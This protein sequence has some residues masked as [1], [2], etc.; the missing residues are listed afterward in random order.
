MEN[1]LSEQRKFERV[2][3][4]SDAFLNQEKPIDTIIKN[5]IDSNSMSKETSL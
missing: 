5:L 4:K 1:F 2:T 3:L